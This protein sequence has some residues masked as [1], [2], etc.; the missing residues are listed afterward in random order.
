MQVETGWRFYSADFS[1]LDRPGCVLLVRDA[2]DYDRWQ[3]LA[4]T[5]DEDE[6]DGLPAL[7][8]SGSGDSFEE[9]LEH[10]NLVAAQCESL[11]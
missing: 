7:Y 11:L 3:E 8:A 10:A 6:S 9:A 5:A 4:R 1:Q 2:P